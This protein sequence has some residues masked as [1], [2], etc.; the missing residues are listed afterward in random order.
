MEELGNNSGHNLP[1]SKL[2]VPVGAWRDGLF[3]VCKHGALHGSAVTGICC[4]GI[5]AA[6]TAARLQLTKFGRPLER[7]LVPAMFLSVVMW[8]SIYWVLRFT[9]VL[10]ITPLDP[11]LNETDASTAFRVLVAVEDSLD[12]IYFLLSVILLCTIRKSLRRQFSIP[13]R[14]CEDEALSL[15]C[16]CLV[17]AQMLR[18]TADYEN[19]SSLYCF[20]A[21]GMARNAPVVV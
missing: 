15:G 19:H 12:G 21:T 3:D 2:N 5:A 20:S 16:P 1:N 8:V 7:H 13:A 9:L 11:G 17:A 6:Q 14:I 18:H 10:A 4:C